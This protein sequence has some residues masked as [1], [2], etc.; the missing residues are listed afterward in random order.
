MKSPSISE[1]GDGY[2]PVRPD[3]LLYGFD[4]FFAVQKRLPGIEVSDSMKITPR[5]VRIFLQTDHIEHVIP[6]GNFPG[7]DVPRILISVVPKKESIDE[8]HLRGVMR[9]AGNDD[10]ILFL[11]FQKY[12]LIAPI[13][14]YEFI[15]AYQEKVG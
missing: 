7:I 8:G 4:I 13:G 11:C 15:D 9:M 3:A 12:F 14:R 2:S 6:V 1:Q 10:G 5:D